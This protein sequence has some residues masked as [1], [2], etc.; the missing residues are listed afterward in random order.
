[1]E[2]GGCSALGRRRQLVFLFYFKKLRVKER[3]KKREREE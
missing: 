3:R 2:R 1:M